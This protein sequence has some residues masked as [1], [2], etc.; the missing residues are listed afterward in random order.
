MTAACCIVVLSVPCYWVCHCN[1]DVKVIVLMI[2]HMKNVSETLK[3]K[4]Y[5][6]LYTAKNWSKYLDVFIV[7]TKPNDNWSNSG[8]FQVSA[9]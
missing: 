6:N 9:K 1:G 3:V 7:Y 4:N 2:N 5:Y 8:M